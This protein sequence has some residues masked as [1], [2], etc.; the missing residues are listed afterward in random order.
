M[1]RST[2]QERNENIIREWMANPHTTTDKLAAKLGFS[3]GVIIGVLDRSGYL[4]REKPFTPKQ[5]KNREEVTVA[6]AVTKEAPQA[7]PI[8]CDAVPV[9]EG[10]ALL[11]LKAHHCRWPVGR[12]A[13]GLAT[14]CGDMKVLKASYCGP[15]H[16]RSR[17][18]YSLRGA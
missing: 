11:N 12:G 7:S 18:G 8:K 14:F 10:V 17:G 6:V 5:I 3:R 16:Q 4:N 1:V 9:P 13:D 2:N 15:H